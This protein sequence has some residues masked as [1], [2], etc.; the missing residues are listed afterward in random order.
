MMLALWM[1]D[2]FFLL[3]KWANSN[4]YWMSRSDFY[5]VVTFSDSMT[6]G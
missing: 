5:L 3:L 2:T 4:A 6:P 1:T